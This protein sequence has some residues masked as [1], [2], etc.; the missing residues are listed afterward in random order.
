MTL[1][2][3]FPL[4]YKPDFTET[5]KILETSEYI[6]ETVLEPKRI[7]A[8]TMYKK[9]ENRNSF[10][11]TYR[12][13]T[14]NS[15]EYAIFK[16]M[17]EDESTSLP[18]KKLL[19][20][21]LNIP[22]ENQPMQKKNLMEVLKKSD[23][24]FAKKEEVP[25]LDQWKN[26]KVV[27]A[28][29]RQTKI[30]KHLRKSMFTQELIDFYSA[31]SKDS[32]LY[33]FTISDLPQHIAGM[34]YYAELNSWDGWNGTSCMDTRQD[35]SYCVA[36]LGSLADTNCYVG[37]LHKNP[38]DVDNMENQLLARVLLREVEIDGI[39]SL[40]AT[41]YYGNQDTKNV[42]DDALKKLEVHMEVYSES[43]MRK[44]TSYVRHEFEH[45]VDTHI[46]N[47]VEVYTSEDDELAK[48]Y[49]LYRT[50]KN[51]KDAKYD[52]VEYSNCAFCGA[53]Y[54]E[55]NETSL[56]TM[57]FGGGSINSRRCYYMSNGEVS[58]NYI[59]HE[60]PRCQNRETGSDDLGKYVTMTEEKIKTLEQLDNNETRYNSDSKWEVVGCGG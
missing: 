54:D 32:G 52:E 1:I 60:C 47:E 2:E 16:R 29:N 9:R 28:N 57:Y 59:E 4:E 19:K 26:G 23:Y 50:S 21:H 15:A 20:K 13:K 58:T 11:G 49:T 30:G 31:Q 44:D 17:F 36:L 6:V 41:R 27:D 14:D 55:S 12:I 45:S 5:T 18:T 34:S 51:K 46:Y 33:C 24:S 35:G 48:N 38:T 3:K 39:K 25:N 22:V 40:I 56:I 53:D 43:S 42:M 10:V 8:Q 37:L 7:T